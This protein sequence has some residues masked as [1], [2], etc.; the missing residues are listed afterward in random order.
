MSS[1][2]EEELRETVKWFE[3]LVAPVDVSG[4]VALW[5]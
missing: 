3:E 4:W 5:P 1:S 2:L